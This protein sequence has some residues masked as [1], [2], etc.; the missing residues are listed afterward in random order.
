MCPFGGRLNPRMCLFRARKVRHVSISEPVESEHVSISDS[1]GAACVYFGAGWIRACVYFGRGERSMRPFRGRLSCQET[2]TST[3]LG[4]TNF[5]ALVFL[6]RRGASGRGAARRRERSDRSY[7]APRP[8]ASAGHG[9]VLTNLR[10]SGI[11][12]DPAR[13]SHACPSEG[14]PSFAGGCRRCWSS[15]SR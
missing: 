15:L 5:Y 8:E 12:P 1:E 3:Q 4:D 6:D 9:R 10:T 2:R 13:P 7:A 11:P 14:L